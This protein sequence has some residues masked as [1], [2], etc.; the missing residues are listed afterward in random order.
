MLTSILIYSGF[1]G[2]TVFI[3]GILG[4][5]FDHHSKESPIKYEITHSM[6]SFG[7]GII[8]SALALVLIPKGLENLDVL[9]MALSFLFGAIVFM[10]LDQYLAKKGGKTATLLAMM[11]DFS[12]LHEG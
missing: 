1:A 2:I 11:M 5:Y 6:M 8:L 10:Y 4:N 9:P 7:A 3:G 12:N